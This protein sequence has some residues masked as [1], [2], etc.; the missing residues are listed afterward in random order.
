MSASWSVRAAAHAGSFHLDV[1]FEATARVVA[2]FGP[3]GAGK[4]TLVECLAG[5]RAFEGAWTLGGRVGGELRVGWVPQEGALFPHLSVGDNIAYAGRRGEAHDRAITV[6]GLEGLLG[7]SPDTLSGGER[8]RVA[9]AR[10]LASEP[11]VLLLDEPLSGVDLPR[12]ASVF[13]WLLEVKAAF[14]VP[15]LYVSHD[16]A[17]V[18]AIADQVVLLDE[19]RVVAA[20]DPAALLEE[21][22]ALR[23][24]G[25]LGFEN[26]F[27]VRVVGEPVDGR[28]VPV[29]TGG[30]TTLLAPAGVGPRSG[31][32]WL[33]V[34]ARDVMLSKAKPGPISARN[35]L[36]GRVVAVRD[37]GDHA[38]VEID[39]GD[40]WVA[41]VTHEA[42]EA[43]ELT[44]EGAVWVVV[45]THALHWLAD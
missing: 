17:E 45:K 27:E 1:A 13:R 39:A 23:L 33:A 35:V 40:K 15:T 2:L 11:D 12:R 6:L 29:L 3:S 21:V 28:A 16:P 34:Q 30:E 26:V 36:E 5:V 32:G 22:T 42:V 38:L 4:S 14:G 9:L 8:Q 41:R 18:L 20:G 7:R 43:L 44:P 25:R 19:G 24:L 31:S 10:A 37:A